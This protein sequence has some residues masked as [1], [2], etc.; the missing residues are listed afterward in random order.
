MPAPNQFEEISQTDNW[1]KY[2]SLLLAQSKLGQLGKERFE[3]HGY[4][5]VNDTVR[6][7]DNEPWEVIEDK[8]MIDLLRDARAVLSRAG[9]QFQD[10]SAVDQDVKIVLVSAPASIESGCPHTYADPRG[11][12]AY[13]VFPGWVR[14]VTSIPLST[15]LHE[16]VHVYQK[17]SGLTWELYL[18]DE[19]ISKILSDPEQLMK[20]L[21]P[22]APGVDYRTANATYMLDVISELAQYLEAQAYD[23]EELLRSRDVTTTVVVLKF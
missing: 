12:T 20:R 21:N 10:I 23:S 1:K 17:L 4:R 9:T 11:A 19:M 7:S 2:A 22:D 13:I 6:P 15:M 18:N 16:C 5:V 8:H 3:S 14:G